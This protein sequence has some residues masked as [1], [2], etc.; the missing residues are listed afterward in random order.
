MSDDIVSNSLI[1]FAQSAVVFIS[2]TIGIVDTKEF[3][4]IEL[5]SK[6][7]LHIAEDRIKRGKVKGRNILISKVNQ[8][9]TN[10]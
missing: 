6:K 4:K 8:G 5:D 1:P 9:L 2:V 10:L 7:L 3:D